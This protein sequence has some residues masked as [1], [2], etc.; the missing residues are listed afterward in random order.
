MAF[1]D[2]ENNVSLFGLKGGEHIA[3]FGSGSGAYAFALARR[4]GFRGR[5]YAVDI[6]KDL[7]SKVKNESLRLG[8]ENVE[9]IWGDAEKLGGAKLGDGTLDGVLLSNILYQVSDK[10]GLL[11]E[12]KRVLKNDGK[13]FLIEWSGS[14]GG[15]GPKPE[16]VVE[17]GA[18]KK[19]FGKLGFAT[20]REINAGT[21][22]YGI[23][24]SKV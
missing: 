15:L 22:H 24:F 14:F 13:V 11:S 19:L 23:I 21:Y 20:E 16:D 2:P 4:V 17:K 9:V 3:D 12:A 1:V 10:E 5:V 18:A 7:L 6:Q 8:L